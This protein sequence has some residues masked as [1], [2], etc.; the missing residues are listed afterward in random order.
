LILATNTGVEGEMGEA[1]GAV[2]APAVGVAL[3][4]LP[5][6]A[7]ILILFSPRA[8]TLGP[9]F[10]LGWVLGMS[11]VIALVL[12]FANP[13][14][15]EDDA[16]NPSTTSAIIHL[17]LGLLLLFLAFK[18]W[19]GRPK[20]GETPE[21]PKWMQSI[22]KVSPLVAFGLGAFL[23]GLNPKNLI[24]TLGAATSI[25]QANLATGESIVVALIFIVIASISVGGAVIW[26]L[27]A[28]ERAT[29]TLTE[30]KDWMTLHNSVVMMVLFLILG[31]SFVG[32]GIGGL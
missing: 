21:M 4:P 15:L 12:I 24:F 1:I 29:A 3:S 17:V 13:A 14:N 26:Y 11:I 30:V 5:I 23:S 25:A 16:S 2:L 19:Q 32:K 28:G 9:L 8:R 6:I 18:Q 31:V 27:V 22:D 20:E 10:A 7:V